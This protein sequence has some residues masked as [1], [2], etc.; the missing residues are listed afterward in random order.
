MQALLRAHPMAGDDGLARRFV[1]LIDPL[2]YPAGG[3][4]PADTREIRRLKARMEAERL[5]RGVDPSAHLKLGRGGLSD[6][7][8]TVQLLQLRHG[9]ERPAL[10]TTAT[11][12]ALRAATD[13]GLL[14]AEDAR[15]LQD[16][17]VIA[18]RVRNAIVLARGRPSDVMPSDARTLAAVARAMGYPAGHSGDLVEDYRRATRRARAVH[19][20][21][22]AG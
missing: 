1:A 7:E 16:A 4:S 12:D 5:P 10:R 9:A 13:A 20:R 19:E 6:V 3:L 8:W 17:W 2:R 15:S 18:T 11:L 14:S 22:F 21:V